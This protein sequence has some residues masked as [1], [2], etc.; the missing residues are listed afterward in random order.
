MHPDL[1]ENV[2]NEENEPIMDSRQRNR[3]SE[4][5]DTFRVK[6]NFIPANKYLDEHNF[7]GFNTPKLNSHFK[8]QVGDSKE[9]ES[10][11][12]RESRD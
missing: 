3:N 7:S 11:R 5:K 9:S 10:I 1:E 4:I 6:N 8:N 2:I 12:D